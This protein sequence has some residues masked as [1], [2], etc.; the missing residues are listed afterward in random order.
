MGF[1]STPANQEGRLATIAA[2]GEPL[3]R[4]I[5]LFVASEPDPVSRDQ[6]AERFGVSRGVA[7]FHLDKLAELSLLDVE[8]R[9]PPGRTGPGAG[10][11]SKLY[12]AAVREVSFSL[13]PR[14]Y[15]LA[16]RL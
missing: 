7:A 10:R 12:R 13:P 5:Y 15:E 9:R 6:A 16:G 2:L 14:E 3:R 11:P 1:V 4:R 8:Y